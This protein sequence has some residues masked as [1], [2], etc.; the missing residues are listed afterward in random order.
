[1]KQTFLQITPH[2]SIHVNNSVLIVIEKLFSS[3]LSG[4]KLQKSIKYSYIFST[5]SFQ[6]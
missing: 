5:L 1:M 3:L 4:Y 6:D 2:F